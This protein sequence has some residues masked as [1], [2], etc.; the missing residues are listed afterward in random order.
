MSPSMEHSTP[1]TKKL[2]K[3]VL[4]DTAKVVGSNKKNRNTGLFQC[5]YR[6]NDDLA[7]FN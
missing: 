6:G 5:I 3:M 2:V 7:K 1:V 4:N